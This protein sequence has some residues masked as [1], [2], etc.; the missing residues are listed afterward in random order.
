[1]QDQAGNVASQAVAFS[2]SAA[3]GCN[4]SRAPGAAGTPDLGLL[5]ALLAGAAFL[6]RCSRRAGARR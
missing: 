3:G 2:V 1:V 5:F 4:V 6:V